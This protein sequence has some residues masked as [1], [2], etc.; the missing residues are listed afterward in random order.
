MCVPWSVHVDVIART[1]SRKCVRCIKHPLRWG[2]QYLLILD[3]RHQQQRIVDADSSVTAQLSLAPYPPFTNKPNKPMI[4]SGDFCGWSTS[5]N[6]SGRQASAHICSF[7]GGRRP[8]A[9]D[10]L[11]RRD[12]PDIERTS[13]VGL[14]DIAR[15]TA[16]GWS[17]FTYRPAD[18][19][20]ACGR[21]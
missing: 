5:A 17:S 10:F 13:V 16:N 12:Q 21:V 6:V 2:R 7:C 1:R 4:T 3:N 9:V 15:Y 11:W 19:W 8:G 18:A 20:V 14:V